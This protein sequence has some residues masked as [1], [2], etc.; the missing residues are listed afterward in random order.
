M[1]FAAALAAAA[2]EDPREHA[3]VLAV[4]RPEELA[5]GVLAEPVDVEE[6]RQLR[7]VGR[8]ADAQPVREVV[9]HVVAAERQH[10]ERVAAQRADRAGRGGGRLGTHDRAEEHAVLPVVRLGDE[11]D[12]RGAAAAEQDRRDRH[13]LRVFPLRRDA[14]HLRERR[15][16]AAVRVGG[17]HA[18]FRRPV[19]ALPVGEVRG[20]VLRQPF[21]PHVAVV[22]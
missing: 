3:A 1:S 17:G 5:V 19:V 16:E 12:G 10:R 15:G 8:F 7:L 20:L 9:A 13:A 14:R 4:A 22:A 21:P 2:A 6:L 18:G 11:R